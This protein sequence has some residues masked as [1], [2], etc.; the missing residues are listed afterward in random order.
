MKNKSRPQPIKSTQTVTPPYKIY[1]KTDHNQINSK[2]TKNKIFKNFEIPY[3]PRSILVLPSK[4]K[5]TKN[6]KTHFF[7]SFLEGAKPMYLYEKQKE[8]TVRNYSKFITRIPVTQAFIEECS[9][10][11]GISPPSWC[12]FP[13]ICERILLV[14]FSFPF[15]L[16]VLLTCETGSVFANSVIWESCIHTYRIP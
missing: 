2:R 8:F 3:K 16:S 6:R 14:L 11:D 9:C 12:Y 15:F 7:G 13:I 10:W 5:R 1:P 4:S